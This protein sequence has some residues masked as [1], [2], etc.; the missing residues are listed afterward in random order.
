MCVCVCGVMVIVK[1]NGH[2]E[3]NLILCFP[4]TTRLL[5]I[6]IIIN[7]VAAVLRVEEARS[8]GNHPQ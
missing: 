1:K 3:L 2:G 8:H 6:I 5:V 4:S 7:R